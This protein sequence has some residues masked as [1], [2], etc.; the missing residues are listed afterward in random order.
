MTGP[1]VAVRPRTSTTAGRIGQKLTLNLGLRFEMYPLMTRE[2]SGIERLDY[3]TYEVLL[4]GRGNTPED[5]GINVKKFY[6]APRLGAIYRLTENTV[7]RA[8]YGRTFNPLPWSRPMRGS[9]PVRHLLQP[10][11]GAVRLA[12]HARAG[13]PAGPDP[14]PQLR[15]REAAARTRSCARPTRPTWTAPS[16]SR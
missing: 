10:D 12:R 2:D 9:Y 11:R 14:G 4:G 15:T 8:G 5:V 7:L 3:T 16:C 13:H 1:R 6:V